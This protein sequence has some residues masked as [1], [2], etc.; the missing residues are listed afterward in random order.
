MLSFGAA[1][2]GPRAQ[3]FLEVRRGDALAIA[4]AMAIAP[5]MPLV[6]TAH[7]WAQ[8]VIHGHARQKLPGLSR[9][10]GRVITVAEYWRSVDR[11]HYWLAGRLPAPV[12]APPPAA[13]VEFHGDA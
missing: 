11:A 9:Y 13:S 8:Y 10:L 4:R 5:H 6:L 2:G 7:M 3:Q 12:S 1:A